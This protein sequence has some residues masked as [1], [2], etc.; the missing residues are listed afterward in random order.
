MDRLLRRK[1]VLTATTT[2]IGNTCKMRTLDVI[3]SCT[4]EIL[5]LLLNLLRI[6]WCS[7]VITCWLT[8]PNSLCRLVL[9]L[10][11]LKKLLVL[12]I[13]K[14]NS[15]IISTCNTELVASMLSTWKLFL[16]HDGSATSRGALDLTGSITATTST[17]F[18]LLFIIKVIWL[19]LLLSLFLNQR[20]L[21]WSRNNLRAYSSIS[22]SRYQTWL[23]RFSNTIP[24][25]VCWA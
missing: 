22:W 23:F 24:L 9:L 14:C 3:S 1:L 10:L 25:W 11:L 12:W 2:S 6:V 18:N 15:S 7:K 19:L 4:I 5:V 8:L 20:L 16:L 17:A 21:L 13:S